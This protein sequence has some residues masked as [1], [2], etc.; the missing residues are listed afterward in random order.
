MQAY[1]IQVMPSVGTIH[2]YKLPAWQVKYEVYASLKS[3]QAATLATLPREMK[4]KLVHSFAGA[5]TAYY[6]VQE[7]GTQARVCTLSIEALPKVCAPIIACAFITEYERDI[8]RAM[9]KSIYR[10]YTGATLAEATR[11]L[12]RVLQAIARDS[13][14]LCKSDY[15]YPIMIIHTAY[16]LQ[17]YMHTLT[18]E[19]NTQVYACY[20]RGIEIEAYARAQMIDASNY[21]AMHTAITGQYI[22][23]G[24]VEMIVHLHREIESMQE[25]VQFYDAEATQERQEAQEMQAQARAYCMVRDAQA[26]QREVQQ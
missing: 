3:A 19:I 18:K 10:P 8:M 7:A 9:Q 26:L 24:I 22:E 12:S 6:E 21:Y 25:R 1:K 4:Y 11:T 5:H 16:A 23:R 2:T 20:E 14:G 13:V 15:N 17:D